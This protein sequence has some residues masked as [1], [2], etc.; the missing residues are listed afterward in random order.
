MSSTRPAYLHHVNFPTSDPERTT[1]WYGDV[2]GMTSMNPRSNSRLL[3]LSR[4]N[5]NLHFTPVDDMDRM[6]PYHFAIEV[7]D[8][9]GFLG[10]LKK[11]GIR[12]TPPGKR[13][14]DHSLFCYIFD[15]DHTMIELVWHSVRPA[16]NSWRMD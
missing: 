5:F 9:E 6:A 13:P 14:M 12:H 3:L 15:P 8:W 16:E 1:K 11:L 10:H 4:G 2:F 7:E